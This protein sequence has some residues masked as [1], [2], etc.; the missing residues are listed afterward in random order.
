MS[1]DV[2]RFILS[3][4]LCENIWV[5]PLDPVYYKY[6]CLLIFK[7][8]INKSIHIYFFLPTV[9]CQTGNTMSKVLKDLHIVFRSQFKG[10]LSLRKY[11]G[12]EN[13]S[14]SWTIHDMYWPFVINLKRGFMQTK[15]CFKSFFSTFMHFFVIFHNF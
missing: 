5:K 13:C 8:W 11:W 1:P 4:Y 6:F 15:N 10:Q 12:F 2:F 9:L 3:R 14:N 7:F